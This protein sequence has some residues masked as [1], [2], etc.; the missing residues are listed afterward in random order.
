MCFISGRTLIPNLYLI[1]GHGSKG[2]T[3]SW[4]SIKMLSD[5]VMGKKTEVSLQKNE[6]VTLY[7][8]FGCHLRV[9]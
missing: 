9:H 4:G 5:I 3:L 6:K 2:W 1:S 7:H 8:A